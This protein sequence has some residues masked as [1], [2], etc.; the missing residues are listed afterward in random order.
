MQTDRLGSKTINRLVS[1]ISFKPKKRVYIFL[2]LESK[3]RPAVFLML[4]NRVKKDLISKLPEVDILDLL[5]KLDPDDTTDALQLM[6]KK[7]Q[8]YFLDKL[9]TDIKETVTNL[10]KF[11]PETA[12][13]LMSIDYI[14]VDID[15]DFETVAKK[16]KEHDKRTGRPPVVI[17]MS[18]DDLIGYLPAYRFGLTKPNEKIKKFVNDILT[19]HDTATKREVIELFRSHPH[20]FVAVIGT[21]SYVIGII[22][23]DDVLRLIHER[24]AASLYNFAG[25]SNEESVM[26][27]AGQKVRFRY[28]WLILNLGTAFLAAFTVSLFEETIAKFVILAVY[29]PIVA[30]MGGNAGTQTL[31]VIVRGLALKQINTKTALK[32]LRNEIGA[33]FI[34]GLINGILVA[35]IVVIFSRD[36]KVAIILGL[37]MIINLIISATFGTIV[38]LIMTK[39]KK[40]PASSATIFITTATDVLGF[41]VFLGLAT[42]ILL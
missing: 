3:Y 7:Q 10:L 34:N 24:E 40:D 42:W 4:S 23:S 17:V 32:A 12:A 8:A 28:R 1:E 35:T 31:A 37:A 27:S 33:A 2:E 21:Q 6:S 38:P 20:K 13:G 36:Y 16:F 14:L 26:A 15:D 39:F 19:I 11:D 25:V 5:G 22:Y 41:L 9:S 29:M 30:G 18:N